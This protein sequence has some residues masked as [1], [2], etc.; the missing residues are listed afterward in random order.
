MSAPCQCW[1]AVNIHEGH[2]CMSPTRGGVCGQGT[3]HYEPG[4]AVYR[5]LTVQ[6]ERHLL[7]RLRSGQST[8]PSLFEGAL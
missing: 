1:V 8:Q 5:S 4:M 6:P 7:L 2:C 3:E